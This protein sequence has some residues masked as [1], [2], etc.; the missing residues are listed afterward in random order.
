MS[1]SRWRGEIAKAADP[2]FYPIEGIEADIRSGKSQLWMLPNCCVI[3]E[4]VDY[5]GE[6]VCQCLWAAGDLSEILSDL[7]PKLEAWAKAQGCQSMLVESREGWARALKPLGYK[8][9][10]VTVRKAL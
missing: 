5:P 4:I 8:P 7:S 9:W 1:W 2:A 3:S 10:S 6:K